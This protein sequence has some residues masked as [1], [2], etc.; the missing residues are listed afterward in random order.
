MVSK[1]PSIYE[2]DGLLYV[3]PYE[4]SFEIRIKERWT[5]KTIAELFAGDFRFL[6]RGLAG[7]AFRLL[8]DGDLK[9][10]RG[11]KEL[12]VNEGHR[13]AP[14]ESLWLKSIS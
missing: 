13:V 1:R 9:L 3:T 2:E 10:A 6:G 7:S 12:R 8:R 11:R 4:R 14:G 5:G